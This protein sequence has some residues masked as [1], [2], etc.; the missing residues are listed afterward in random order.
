M[1]HGLRCATCGATRDLS[2]FAPWRCPNES[3]DRHHV[4]LLDPPSNAATDAESVNPFLRFRHRMAW[5]EFALASGLSDAEI[6]SLVANVDGQLV[7]TSGR[8]FVGTPISRSSALSDHLGFSAKGGV[9]IKD[10]TGNVGGSQKARHLMSILL[11]LLIAE[12]TGRAPWK[13]TD[14]PALAIS[15]CGNAAIAA[16]TLA[17]AVDWPID[18][19]IPEWAGGNVVAT[20]D[21][22]GARIARCPR[23]DD[24]PPGDPTVLRFREAVARGAIPFSVQGPENALCLDGGRTFGWELA[25]SMRADGIV[26]VDALFVQVGGGAFAAS[27]SRGARE[28]GLTAPLFATQTE[29]CAPL[30]RAWSTAMDDDAMASHWSRHMRAW[31]AEP[32]S[33]ADGILDDETYDWVADVVELRATRGRVVVANENNVVRAAE[34]ARPITGIDVSPTGAAGLAGLLEVR[35]AFGDEAR[36]VLAFSGVRRD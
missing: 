11:H 32:R 13:S 5:H 19:F 33:L 25:E 29:G 6:V 20:L 15:S 24:D 30:S 28:G 9:W 14:R 23:R 18:V 8:G 7:A 12:R 1:S 22:L 36:V 34:I 3:G 31:D 10:E 26:A 27:V 17:R 16:S 21:A 35:D 4:L 2:E